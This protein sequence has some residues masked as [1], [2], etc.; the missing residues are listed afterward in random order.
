MRRHARHIFQRIWECKVP[1]GRGCGVQQYPA[2]FS[3]TAAAAAVANVVCSCRA[4]AF[5]FED[6]VRDYIAWNDSCTKDTLHDA[7]VLGLVLVCADLRHEGPVGGSRGCG[8]FGGGGCAVSGLHFK[9]VH[10]VCSFFSFSHLSLSRHPFRS[11]AWL[12]RDDDSLLV[13]SSNGSDLPVGA[14]EQTAAAPNQYGYDEH[15]RG[16]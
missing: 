7:V 12:F 2:C 3:D 9:Y 5:A 4:W 14:P 6:K 8:W 15:N 11:T 10:N 1:T 16:N 13:G